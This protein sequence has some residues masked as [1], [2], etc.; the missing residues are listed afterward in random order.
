MSRA[1][2]FPVARWHMAEWHR[3]AELMGR[4]LTD[5]QV[6]DLQSHCDGCLKH[7]CILSNLALEAKELL[8]PIRPKLHATQQVL[9]L[10]LILTLVLICQKIPRA[11]I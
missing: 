6:R 2:L 7:Y 3:K 11:L 8:F 9:V 5:E 4:Y 1:D 10:I